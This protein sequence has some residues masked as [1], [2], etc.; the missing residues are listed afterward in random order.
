MGSN[1]NPSEDNFDVE[2]VYRDVYGVKNVENVLKNKKNKEQ[3][4]F[5]KVKS[6]HVNQT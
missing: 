3:E 4:F 5:Q 2:E 1:S 6:D